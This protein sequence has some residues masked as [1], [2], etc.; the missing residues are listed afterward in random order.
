MQEI[1]KALESTPSHHE[2][3]QCQAAT[4]GYA[5]LTYSHLVN[6]IVALSSCEQVRL[7]AIATR[8]MGEI[9]RGMNDDDVDEV[10]A[11]QGEIADNGPFADM[12][13]NPNR[14]K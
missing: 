12:L 13:I 2:A 8:R 11:E 14:S 10:L 5:P 6:R 3:T 7:Y 4:L 1:I 9:G